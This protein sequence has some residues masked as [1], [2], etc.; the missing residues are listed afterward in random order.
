MALAPNARHCRQASRNPPQDQA[1]RNQSGLYC[2]G[3]A[4]QEGTGTILKEGQN[5]REYR[6]NAEHS[7]FKPCFRNRIIEAEILAVVDH[8]A[9]LLDE[10]PPAVDPHEPPAV[11]LLIDKEWLVHCLT[12]PGGSLSWTDDGIE[13]VP[14]PSINAIARSGKA[15]SR[16]VHILESYIEHVIPVT[17]A[18]DLACSCP[19]TFP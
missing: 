17:M 15:D 9:D 2:G 19:F 5:R 8:D 12:V 3:S 1:T 6:R 18:Q 16:L 10:G 4:D 11:L 13:R 7:S 14:L